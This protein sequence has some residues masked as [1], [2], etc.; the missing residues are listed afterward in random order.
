M[1][2]KFN[3]K[4]IDKKVVL[5][6]FVLIQ[7][8]LMPVSAGVSYWVGPQV[9]DAST[10]V[11]N[12]EDGWLVASNATI[13]EGS[14]NVSE[15][16]RLSGGDGEIW[17]AG[18]PVNNFSYSGVHDGTTGT[19]FEDLLSLS[20]NGSYGDVDTLDE[21]TY[22]F[23][24]GYSQSSPNIWDVGELTNVSGSVVGNS[25][26]LPYG[27]IP[28]SPFSGSLSVGTMI[29][30]PL[31]GGIDSWLKAPSLNI[32]NPVNQFSLK[33]NHWDHFAEGDGS[34]L[35]Y[36]L[37]NGPWTWIEPDSGYLNESNSSAP[38]PNGAIINPVS[39]GFGLFGNTTSSGWYESTFTLDNIQ[40]LSQSSVIEFRLR[41]WTSVNS[42]ARPGIFIDD[43]SIM[44]IGGSTGYWHHGYYD[45]NGAAG[46]YSNNADSALEVEVDLS[47][48]VAPITVELT[49][50]W[51]LEG[52]SYDNFLVE[53]SD[54]GI[55]WT[56]ITNAGN[57]YGIPNNGYTVN[58]INYNDE[59]GTFLL[60]DF[61][62]PSSY[63]GDSTTFLRL[64]IS[65]DGSITYGDISDSLEGLT[66]DRIKV[67]D[68]SSTVLFDDHF[69]NANTATHYSINNGANDWDY[70]MIGA[71]G[72]SFTDGFENSNSVP[73]SDWTISN[74]SGIS[75]MDYGTITSC[76]NCG[77]YPSPSS[78][79]SSPYGFATGLDSSY[80]NADYNPV[81]S[82]IYSPEYTIPLGASARVV[83]DH[84]ICSYSGY[85]AGALFISD[86]LGNTWDHFNPIDPVTGQGWYHGANMYNWYSHALTP[87]GQNGP[88]LDAWDGSTGRGCNA[89]NNWDS[90]VGDIT[91]YSGSTVQ[92]RFTFVSVYNFQ[93]PGWYID[94]IG[95]EID[96]FDQ[97]GEWISPL[98]SG[99]ELGHG[100]LDIFGTSPIDGEISANL[101]DSNM[102]P[103]PG[104][105]D[106]QIPLSFSGL[107]L[108]EY[109]SGFY[110][111]INLAT[112]NPF[113]SPLIEY[114]S[115][116]S[117][118]FMFGFDLE[119]NS[120]SL[121][122][123]LEINDGN[124]TSGN[125]Q[126]GII[127][128]PYIPSTQPIHEI[129]VDGTGSGVLVSITDSK[130]NKYGSLPLQ[131][132]IVLPHPL[133]GYGIEIELG[134]GDWIED[135]TAEGTFWEPAFNPEIDVVDDGTID[136]LFNSN[137]NYGH[138][139]WQNRIAGDNLVALDGTNSE[140]ILVGSISSSGPPGAGTNSLTVSSNLVLDGSHSFDV[141]NI[142][143]GGS[144]TPSNC[145]TLMITANEINV[146]AGGAI[147]AD[148]IVWD[149][150]G[151]GGHEI[152]S[153]SGAGNGAGGAGHS[154]PGHNGA[155]VN[156]PN[157]GGAMYGSGVECGSSGGNITS[158]NPTSGGRGGSTISLLSNIMTIDGT[159]SSNGENAQD[160]QVAPGGTGP[161]GHGAG[162]GSAGSITLQANSIS[163]GTTGSILARGGDG[164]DGAD[165]TQGPNPG[166]GMY[167]GGN[168]GGSGSG[169]FIEIITMPNGLTNDGL[170]SVDGGTSGIGGSAY[171]TGSD[172]LDAG[173]SQVSNDGQVQYNTF[174][175]F[176][177]GS[178]STT[179]LIPTNSSVYEGVIT[180]ITDAEL[181]SDLDLTIA[182]VQINTISSGWEVQHIP[183]DPNMI[184]SIN[185]LIGTHLDQT[186]R[187]WSELEIE[188]STSGNS[189][190]VLLGGLAIGY[191][192]TEMVTGLE[193]QMYEY[194]EDMK[195]QTNDDEI[196]IPI[197]L[198]ADKGG[199][200]ING[201][202]YHELM[203]TNEPFNVPETI[204]PNGQDVT[205][206][207]G[208]HHLYSNS[209]ID[210]ITLT[211]EATSG[212][213]IMFELIELQTNP[214]FV[215]TIG[216]EVVELNTSSSLVRLVDDSWIVDWIFES[217]W[218]WDDEFEI[219]WSSQAY[220]HTGYGLAPATALSGGLGTP[221]AV[222]NDLEIDLIQFKDQLDRIIEFNP[223][224]PPWVQGSSVV[225]IAGT[226]RFQN[227]VDNRPLATDF[228]TS[229]NLSGVELIATSSGS[230][231][232]S[233]DVSIPSFEADGSLRDLVTITPS[234]LEAG[235]IGS[236]NAVDVT[237]PQ[238][239]SMRVD[240]SAP[241]VNAIHARTNFGLKDA[242]GYTWDPSK[243]LLLQLDIEELE[244]MG[245][246][247]NIHYWRE[248]IDD[249]NQDGIAQ[250]DEYLL[251]SK[252]L[253][254]SRIGEQFIELPPI[255]L[256]GNENNAKVSLYVSGTDF[257][258]LEF[259]NG[260]GPGLG[261]DLATIVT[262]INTVTELDYSSLNL[263][264]FEER[265][266]LG[267]NHTLE[268]IITEGN[269]IETIDEIRIQLL[270]SQKAPRGEIVYSPKNNE[271]WTLEDDPLTTEIE[272][273]FV[274]VLGVDIE[275]LGSDKY[276]IST[277]FSLSW[278]FP[279]VLAN[280]WQFPSIL[281][282][283]DDLD[284]PII[285]TM[286]GDV[287][288]IKW[289]IDYELKAVVDILED[290]TPPISESS[291]SNLIVRQGDEVFVSGHIE[292]SDSSAIITNVPSGLTVNF[293]LEYGTTRLQDEVNVN[294]DG[295]FEISFLLPN[296]PLA[297]PNLD[298]IL[299]IN[300]LPGN[301]EDDSESRAGVTVDSTAPNLQFVGQTLNVLYSDNMDDLTITVQVY[302]EI[303][304]P[305]QP[306][307]LNWVFR[308]NGADIAGS[309]NSLDFN[310]VSVVGSLWTYQVN[311]DFNP[312]NM[313]NLAENPQLL[314][315]VEGT[316]VAGFELQGEGIKQV[317]LSPALVLKKF[318]PAISYVDVLPNS[319]SIIEVGDV[320]SV[321]VTLVNEGNQEGNVNLSLV[322]SDSQ[323]IWRTVEK[324][325]ITLSPGETN[326]LDSFSFTVVNSGQQSLYLMLNNDSINLQKVET[327]FVESLESKESGFLGI[328]EQGLIGGIAII[329]ILVVISI[330]V[331]ILRRDGD[332]EYWYEEDE[333]IYAQSSTKSSGKIAPPPPNDSYPNVPNNSNHLSSVSRWQDLPSNGT[334]DSRE[335]ANWYVTTDGQQWKQE[336]DGSFNRI[337]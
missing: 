213:F 142:V 258:G 30:S 139:G 149:G 116:G 99:N 203:I 253:V 135:L 204:Y 32:P 211:G 95:V 278:D 171:G 89:N 308:L 280:N 19:H 163:I 45:P 97:E 215:Q 101:Y 118:R 4:K 33:F 160:G 61:T 155:G 266:L 47:T 49:A 177:S 81:E 193:N 321:T 154:S 158:N 272:G 60:M 8:L 120:W 86:D 127:S 302:E 150:P 131:S 55:S 6:L 325:S 309:Q 296:R 315:W 248:S 221:G 14:F 94:N 259:A 201:E 98:I 207:T 29:G 244:G 233:A 252:V 299:E 53:S 295:S 122:P 183:L 294:Y 28:A 322:E 323:G 121:D 140:E 292:Y 330:I 76:S 226:V 303:G 249:I 333:E 34:W 297:K 117:T 12:T 256:E 168:G 275:D 250:E 70:V 107:D 167:D 281:I 334:W 239:Y 84:W 336:K 243:S 231:Q 119:V 208:H 176:G 7:M 214:T 332:E 82:H 209:E 282:Y 313:V 39:G 38:I 264:T 223:G 262:A 67:T 255:E 100:F 270:G 287:N 200:S 85:A 304:M 205:I 310:L 65:T 64:H 27:E 126:I 181:S 43:L 71:G 242:D 219:L 251:K 331:I 42:I 300:G 136:W 26:I 72:L 108:D 115:I 185:G 75:L 51:D 16:T 191:H 145:G 274:N 52:S 169:G 147:I 190:E 307:I 261:N 291:P 56:D 66:V 265:L 283:D 198:K 79:A 25:R 306:P 311:V 35:E 267:Q 206:V 148:S 228:I 234:I 194:H 10:G 269:G 5:C 172:G 130:G 104:F 298:I 237:N 134:A 178:S 59:S 156:N 293:L 230:G 290:L 129:Y 164:G 50:E 182:G 273:S 143:N 44:N 254:E 137:P 23:E 153:S 83:F 87:N 285:E 146:Q 40:G 170:I 179:I 335:D 222:E 235:P 229:L 125:G 289:K 188:F 284:N 3:N 113:I 263:D 257:V 196:S 316:D 78:A 109:N 314:V 105:I 17:G 58:G 21:I 20:P 96:Y 192:I 241:T 327:P 41:V 276:L 92:F 184:S 24:F 288:Q 103:I 18:I 151:A 144:I 9:M 102:N 301:A 212:Q 320:I 69:T 161:G 93:Y 187:E 210:R 318:E 180:L 48:A 73:S 133:S 189:Y 11:D 15:S 175:G 216:S 312:Q 279:V 124:I 68:S 54:D 63:A 218:S 305:Q 62:I 157:N 110:V 224:I 227:T 199:V 77:T 317:P 36:R 197:T 337:I 2:Y 162:G 286:D 245:D 202:I 132:R 152:T 268:M 106:R 240:T 324:I 247:V 128:S 238:S 91:S 277:K 236:I 232:W 260:G 112:Q 46:G 88:A 225:E 174:S 246:E 141:L 138:F 13:L 80:Y 271:W 328:D 186:G 1:K 195:L 74:P 57:T 217:E 319:Q 159:I 326:R 165:G 166:I 111:G 220:N 31:V 90:M 173:F 329:F 114:I 123:N 22:G 37:D